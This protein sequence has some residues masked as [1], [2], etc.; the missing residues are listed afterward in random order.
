M[1]ITTKGQI[2]KG[3][4]N[5]KKTK[6]FEGDSLAHIEQLLLFSLEVKRAAKKKI[7]TGNVFVKDPDG[8]IAKGREIADFSKIKIDDNFILDKFSR[9]CEIQ[10]TFG[11][12]TGQAMAKLK[13][14]FAT[15]KLAFIDIQTH[16]ARRT[17][18]YF[19]AKAKKLGIDKALFYSTCLAVYR[20]LFEL[21]AEANETV[22]ADYRWKKGIC[23]VCGTPAGMACFEEE[24]GKRILWCPLCGTEWVFK[25]L[26]CPFCGNENQKTMR[27][28]V[29][30]D[31]GT[32]Y[33]VDIC[34]RCKR[35]VKTV[36]ERKRKKGEKTIFEIENMI[37]LYLDS[38]AKK[39]GFKNI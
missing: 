12:E 24:V 33:R 15:G 35:Y 34:D 30:E 36:D 2:K 3:I 38:C 31:E 7:K 6:Q 27:Y 11:S 4:R 1:A 10:T 8:Y 32:P 20:P 13:D 29:V 16:L 21:C 37:T 18:K 22:L 14:A 28:F 5:I 25:R 9:I 26:Q 39:E 19:S 17:M 23:P